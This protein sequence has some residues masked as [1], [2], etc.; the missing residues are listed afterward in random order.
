DDRDDAAPG[1]KRARLCLIL[2]LAGGGLAL[3]LSM[4]V[5]VSALQKDQAKAPDL[6]QKMRG[7]EWEA[8]RIHIRSVEPK[9][10][11]GAGPGQQRVFV[12]SYGLTHKDL[13]GIS[14]LPSVAAALPT[15]TIVQEI[16]RLNA[17]HTG[18]LIACTPE[19]AEHFAL[20]PAS[21]R[22]FSPDEN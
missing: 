12:K 13:E 19:L 20:T 16:R 7:Q 9:N 1:R 8:R 10:A 4:V 2:G 22:F 3:V 14:A 11:A 6:A 17:L 5:V 18:T 15:R 21:G